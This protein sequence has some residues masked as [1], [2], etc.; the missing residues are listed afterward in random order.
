MYQNE[1]LEVRC[2]RSE[3]VLRNLICHRILVYLAM[4]LASRKILTGAFRLLYISPFL[5]Q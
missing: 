2:K 5:N 3:Y 4:F 1:W